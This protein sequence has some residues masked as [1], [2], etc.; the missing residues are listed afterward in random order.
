MPLDRDARKAQLA[1]AVW[2]V[3]RERGIG[4]VSVRTVAEEAGVVVGSLRHVFPTRTELV[5]FSAELMVTRATERI[6]ATARTG[7]AL[8]DAVAM[9]RHLLPLEPDSRAE[10]EVNIALIAETPALPELRGIRDEA[11]RGLAE[12]CVLLCA[13]VAGRHPDAELLDSA[14]RLHALVDG[15]AVHLLLREGE[16][17]WAVGVLRAELERLRG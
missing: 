13:S 9:L 8:A 7:D 10:L 17:E 6:L 15:L 11:H 1:E 5:A 2:R 3:V 12:M 4:A 14:R 16:G